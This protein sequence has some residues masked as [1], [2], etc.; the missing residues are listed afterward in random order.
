MGE[1]AR[2]RVVERFTLRQT[3]DTFRAIYLELATLLRTSPAYASTATAPSPASSE[4]AMVP[5]STLPGAAADT[6]APASVAA[7]ARS[8][9]G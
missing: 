6:G 1:A 9:A 5:T 4:P 7:D 8:L 2:L 3:I